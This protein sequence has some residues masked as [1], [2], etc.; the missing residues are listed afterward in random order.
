MLGNDEKRFL[1]LRTKFLTEMEELDLKIDQ[2]TD[3]RNELMGLL[4]GYVGETTEETADSDQ[5]FVVTNEK[6]DE[7]LV[8]FVKSHRKVQ[9]PEIQDF[10]AGWNISPDQIRRS[11]ERGK[12]RGLIKV[13]GRSKAAVWTAV[14]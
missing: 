14:K 7:A 3:R 4:D 12:R 1:E 6:I 9:R 5:N 10:F 11:L 2:L 8:E 13:T